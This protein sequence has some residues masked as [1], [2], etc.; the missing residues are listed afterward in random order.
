MN[1]Q[2][3]PTDSYKETIYRYITPG[4]EVVSAPSNPVK[5]SEKP[6]PSTTT[7]EHGIY[8]I[9]RS[10]LIIFVIAIIAVA[11]SGGVG[12][13][14]A[15]QNAKKAC[16]NEKAIEVTAIT[17]GTTGTTAS[18]TSSETASSAATTSAL[19][20]STQPLVVPTGIVKLDCPGLDQNITLQLGPTSWMF[21]TACNTNL[22]GYDFASIISHSFH[23]CVQA[24][25][26]YNSFSGKN[27]CLAITFSAN[28]TKYIPGHY[29]NCWMKN[30][31]FTEGSG[32][33]DLMA[34]AQ[35]MS[36]N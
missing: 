9:R 10:T 13:S 32:N 7:R 31:T 21:T 29:G 26:A 23:D 5:F 28:Q 33:Q 12:G 16:T 18:S 36:G 6:V 35:L 3:E 19:A 4:L 15:V 11:V 14:I 34:S 22:K 30:H 25:A 2:Q 8:H 1:Y 17:T 27:D 24:C 20:A